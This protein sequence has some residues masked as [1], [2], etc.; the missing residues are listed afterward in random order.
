MQIKIFLRNKFFL[1]LA[2]KSFYTVFVVMATIMALIGILLV[3]FFPI[4]MKSQSATSCYNYGCGYFG[5]TQQCQC[6]REC[7]NFGDCCSDF[8]TICKHGNF[9]ECPDAPTIK[10]DRRTNKDILR[11]ISFNIEWLFLDYSHS[12]GGNYCPGNGCDWNNT[13]QA[14]IHLDTV[15]QY[16]DEFNADIIMLQETCDCWTIQQLINAMPI[17]GQYYRPYLL[18]GIIYK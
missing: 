2:E 13:P 3:Y 18:R 6:N 7:E 16:L 9:E 14:N 1:E 4:A 12:M 11:F 10:Q 15:A 5:S 17:N 8:D